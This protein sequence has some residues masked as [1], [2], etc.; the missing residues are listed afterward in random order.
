MGLVSG[1]MSIPKQNTHSGGIRG[2]S[3]GKT[4]ENYLTTGTNSM[5]GFLES[6]SLTLIIWYKHPFEIILQSIRQ[7][8]I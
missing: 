5:G 8:I 4:S 7:G 1:S 3:L 6:K 2:R